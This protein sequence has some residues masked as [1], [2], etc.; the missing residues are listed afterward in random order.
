MDSVPISA[1]NG[2]HTSYRSALTA[3]EEYLAVGRGPFSRVLTHILAGDN[4]DRGVTDPDVSMRLTRRS[5]RDSRR[6]K[7]RPNKRPAVGMVQVLGRLALVRG[8][9]CERLSGWLAGK[10]VSPD[11]VY[12]RAGCSAISVCIMQSRPRMLSAGR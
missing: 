3:T 2:D 12:A 8:D 6:C 9:T 4:A 10:W 11:C 1:R 7:R 5:S